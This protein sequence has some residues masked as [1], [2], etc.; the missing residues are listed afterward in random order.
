MAIIERHIQ[1]LHT[2]DIDVYKTWEKGFE[3]ADIKAGGFPRKRHFQVVSG[4]DA[5][6][7]VIWEREWESVSA[8]DAAYAKDADMPEVQELFKRYRSVLERELMEIIQPVSILD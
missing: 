1:T 6:G 3:A 8:M 5:Q 4:R 2:S 7:T